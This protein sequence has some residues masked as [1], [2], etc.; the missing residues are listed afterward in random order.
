MP[1][2]KRFHLA[3]KLAIVALGAATLAVVNPGLLPAQAA[4]V[5]PPTSHPAPGGYKAVVTSVTVGPAGEQIG[6]V[7]ID[8]VEVTLTI[9]PGP[10]R[11]RSRSPSSRLTRWGG[12]QRPRLPGRGRRRCP[13]QV[14]GKPYTGPF[15]HSLTLTITG[16]AIT[17]RD[18][19]AAWN[20]KTF[21]FVGVHRG[22]H[23]LQVSF[24]AAGG[25]L[26]RPGS[27]RGRQDDQGRGHPLHRCL[28]RGAQN[29]VLDSVFFTPGGLSPLGRACSPPGGW[30][31][32]VA[33]PMSRDRLTAG[34]A[35][36]SPPGITPSS[37]M[38]S[39]RVNLEG[40]QLWRA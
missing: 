19:L 16:A 17:S 39:R 13:D 12:Q 23:A 26:H 4:Y 31:L 9:P 34:P 5:P 29:A 38:P 20:G 37:A 28:P 7:E 2:A 22:R 40:I 6:P 36:C 3:Q 15:G 25:R 18:R 27:H 24:K 30:R 21:V 33:E 1:G 35:T 11:P 32:A 14:N 10:S 8:G